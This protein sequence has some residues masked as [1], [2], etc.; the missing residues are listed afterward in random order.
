MFKRLLVAAVALAGLQAGAASLV[1]FDIASMNK[2]TT[3]VMAETR[4]LPWKI[5]ERADYGLDLAGLLTGKMDMLVREETSEGIW[6]EQNIDL[7]I[8]KQKVETLFDKETGEVKRMLVD[9]QEQKLERGEPP[10]ILESRPENVT[11]PAGTFECGYIKMKDKKDGTVSELW[12]NPE[13]IP[14]MG[15]IKLVS[16]SQIGPV[17][18]ELASFVKK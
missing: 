15:L 1:K 2:L 17:T 10:E 6:L 18:I 13:V 9:G 5:G 12:I 7:T 3:K 11:V 8:Q 4:G 14:I 16:E